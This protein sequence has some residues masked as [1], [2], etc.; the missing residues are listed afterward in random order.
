MIR[1]RDIPVRILLCACVGGNT[2]LAMYDVG[3]E[4]PFLAVMLHVVLAS[5]LGALGIT[6]AKYGRV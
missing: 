4:A 1:G 3:S 6:A 2:F 5:G